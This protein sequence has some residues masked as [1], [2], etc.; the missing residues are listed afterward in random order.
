MPSACQTCLAIFADPCSR[1]SEE[2]SLAMLL[3]NVCLG[4]ST[5]PSD[6]ALLMCNILISAKNLVSQLHFGWFRLWLGMLLM[7]ACLDERYMKA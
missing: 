6:E 4:P 3:S 2:S 1:S 5:D 7:H